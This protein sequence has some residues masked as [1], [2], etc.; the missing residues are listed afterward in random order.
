MILIL[1]LWE[2]VLI[3]LLDELKNKL[4]EAV[5]ESINK[6]KSFAIAFSGGIDSSLLA[7]ICKDTAMGKNDVVLLTIGFPHSNDIEFSKRIAKKICLPHKIL[8]LGTEDFN[9]NLEYIMQ[10]IGCINVSHIENC[11]AYFYIAKLAHENNL[12]LVLTA[13][14]CDELFCGYNQFRMIYNQG[15]TSIM[16]LIDERINNEFILAEEIER[17]TKEFGVNTKQ[18]FLSQKFISF[19]K[20]IP[21][22]QK[23][24]GSD[25]LI[26]K[27]ILRELAISMGLPREAAMRPK[28]ALQYSSLIDKNFKKHKYNNI[29]K[30]SINFVL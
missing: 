27:H 14:G 5:I 17:I 4:F 22:D 29:T 25:D 21:L 7:K 6:E 28:K 18:P 2:C 24:K 3:L 15:K 30:S 26:R 9:K 11:V 16:N 19:A 12:R 13:N 23:I 1:H 8:E 20:N 10:R